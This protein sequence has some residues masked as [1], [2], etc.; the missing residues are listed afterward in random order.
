MLFTV[1]KQKQ[2]V[3]FQ[4][5]QTQQEKYLF[6]KTVAK[7]IVNRELDV[8]QFSTDW[9]GGMLNRHIK[10]DMYNKRGN[11]QHEG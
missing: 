4:D 7:Y 5:I 1:L 2:K 3:P 9:N 8:E 6:K 10:Q 11:L